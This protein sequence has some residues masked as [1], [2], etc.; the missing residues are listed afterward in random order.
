MKKKI[1]IVNII[2]IFSL[3][4]ISCYKKDASAD[5]REIEMRL[6]AQSTISY[7]NNYIEKRE[8]SLEQFIQNMSLPEKIAQLF[9]INVEGNSNYKCIESFY[10]ITLNEDD[11]KYPLIPGGYL[12]FSYNIANS[13]EEML[14]FNQSI[15][16]FASDNKQIKPYLAIDQ[17]GGYVDRLKSLSSP[18]PSQEKIA[19]NKSLSQAY[20]IYKNQALFMKDLGFN[21]NF[22]PVLEAASIYNQDF[23]AGRTF[24]SIEKTLEYGPACVSAYELNGIS[25]VVKHFPGNTNT[26]PHTGLPEIFLSKEELFESI[27]PFKEIIPYKPSG[28][29]MSHART[30][31]IDSQLPSC[32]SKIWVSE[33]LRE[34]FGY[35][36]IIFSD[37]IFMGALSNNGFSPELAA[38]MAIEAGVDSIMI[39][40]K[41]FA[42]PARILYEKALQDKSFENKIDDS[43]KRILIHKNNIGLVEIF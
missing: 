42:K 31:C 27:I 36:G 33:I 1:I 15:F 30:A 18:L 4:F 3:C 6:S 29:L 39:S 25:S 7:M 8:S 17:E 23:L 32:F 28:I 26:D 21:M 22:A 34:D 37:D 38:L 9:I 43:L 2:L 12:F 41:R 10:D 24:G 35:D 40:E 16:D 5:L 20:D 11:K 14:S 19:A 13:P